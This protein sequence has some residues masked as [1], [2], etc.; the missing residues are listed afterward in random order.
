MQ[1]N[2]TIETQEFNGRKGRILVFLGSDGK[3]YQYRLEKSD[4]L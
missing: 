1:I 3:Q 4:K 2:E